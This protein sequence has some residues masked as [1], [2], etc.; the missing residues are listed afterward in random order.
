MTASATSGRRI[1]TISA[2]V[3]AIM[4]LA[5][6]GAGTPS[7]PAA[8]PVLSKFERRTGDTVSRD[9]GYSSPL[10]GRPGWSM[11]LF[12]D[13]VV[14]GPGG[15]DSGGQDSGGHGSGG[16]GSSGQALRLILGA[17]T[18]AAGPYTP[19]QTPSALSEIP[20]PRQV[21]AVPPA[22]PWPDGGGPQP[23]TG[24]PEN[25]WLPGGAGPCVGPGAYPA[26]WISGVARAPATA[27]GADLLITFDD[28]CVTGGG[29]Y[30]PEGFAIAEY[31]PAADV[32]SPPAPVFRG[33]AGGGTGGGAG[34][35]AGGALPP[36]Q[37]LGSPVVRGGYLY[38]FSS[39][40]DVEWECGG[41]FVAR[42]P[43]AHMS[44]RDPFAYQYWTGSG[45]SPRPAASGSLLG[46]DRPLGISAGDFTADGHGL[47]LIEQTSLAGDFSVWQ[48]A[49]PA[50]PWHRVRSGR[51]P[52]GK[53]TGH[54]AEE[55]CRAL[56]GHAELSTRESLLIS[57]FN[58]GTGHV[59]VS[60][61][62]W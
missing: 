47:V 3:T 29:G 37:V 15:Q 51:V 28:Y 55:L 42:V 32:L 7:P 18:A 26:A 31:D 9:C 61:Y 12:C 48:A 58:P 33:A 56:I 2:I 10:P 53:G 27:G 22:A 36:W 49:S 54:G 35:A 30:E 60:A 52:C 50:G 8:S 43:A 40:R 57:Y 34:G 4:L 11:W 5:A 59:D 14:T 17:D 23:F 1:F 39:C 16:H 45:W 19:G 25:L 38:L 46:R 24:V 20:T 21:P 62:R 6:C 44:W 41:V 13:T